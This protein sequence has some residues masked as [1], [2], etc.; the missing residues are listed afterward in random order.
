MGYP[1]PPSAAN[2]VDPVTVL[3]LPAAGRSTVV[4]RVPYRL[5]VR[6]DEVYGD[7]DRDDLAY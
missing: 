1:D 7:G 5:G 2:Q 3:D 4:F 6:T